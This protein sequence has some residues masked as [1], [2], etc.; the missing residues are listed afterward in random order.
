MI[1]DEIMI[2]DGIYGI[3][4]MLEFRVLECRIDYGIQWVQFG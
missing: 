4:D 1:M 2:Y 3:S